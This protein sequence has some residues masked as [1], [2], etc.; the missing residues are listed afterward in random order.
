M[1][2]VL[3]LGA[4]AEN[5]TNWNNPYLPSAKS[6]QQYAIRYTTDAMSHDANSAWMKVGYDDSNWTLGA[7]PVGSSG[8]GVPSGT[9]ALGTSINSPS[10][11]R[12]IRREFTLDRDLSGKT[13]YMACGHDDEGAIWIDGTQIISWGNAWDDKYVH[14]MTSEQTALLTKGKHVIAIWA[15][16]NDG[17]YYWDCGLYGDDLST[18]LDWGKNTS[19]TAKYMFKDTG[20]SGGDPGENA[21]RQAAVDALTDPVDDAAGYDWTKTNYNDASWGTMSMPCGSAWPQSNKGTKWNGY[22]NCYWFRRSF[23]LTSADINKSVTLENVHDDDYEIYINGHLLQRANGW[24]DNYS[25]PVKLAIPSE[26][27]LIGENVIA[28]EVQQNWGGSLFDCRLAIESIA[29]VTFTGTASDNRFDGRNG[30]EEMLDGDLDTK[31]EAWPNW[32]KG[33]SETGHYGFNDD[34]GNILFKTST[35][36]YV[37]GLTLYTAGDTQDHPKRNPYEWTLF[38]SN[39]DA[40]ETDDTHSSWVKIEQVNYAQ[41]PT[42]NKTGKYFKFNPSQ[43]AYKYFKFHVNRL[44]GQDELQLAELELDYSTTAKSPIT[45]LADG[46][47]YGGEGAE[48]IFDGT[49]DTKWCKSNNASTNWV[50][51][52]TAKPIWVSN[53]IIQTAHN[54]NEE[55]RDPKKFKLYA[56]LDAAPTTDGSTT[57]WT[58]IDSETDASSTIPTDRRAFVDFTIDTPGIYQYF[59][60]KVEEIR[61]SDASFQ[62]SEFI[63]GD[64]IEVET[65]NISNPTELA[66]LAKRV[67]SGE[68]RVIAKITSDIVA[69]GNFASIGTTTNKFGGRFDGQG[70]TITISVGS[71]SE[72]Q[73]LIGCADTGASISNVIVKGAV[74]GPARCGGVLGGSNGATGTIT[75][76]NCGNEASVTVAG[77]NAGGV[78]GCNS[79]GSAKYYLTNCYN[80]GIIKGGS[81][82]AGISGWLGS[83]AVV[84]NCYNIGDVTGVDGT[85]TFARWGSGTYVNCYN[86]LAANEFAGRTDSYP[87]DKVRSGE[88]CVALGNAFTQDLSGDNYPTFGSKTVTA[89]KWFND[90]DVDVYYNKVD[91]DYTVYQLN[92]NEENTKYAVPGAGTVTAKNVSVARNIPAGQWIGLCLPFDYD[93]P[94]GWDVRELDHVNGSGESASMV[95]DSASSIEAGKPY[96]VNPTET[97]TNITAENKTISAA[98][99]DVSDS[100]VTMKG[101]LKKDMIQAGDFY[102][103][104]SSQV[105]KLNVSEVALKGF[106]AYFTVD[107]GSGVK[108]LSFDIEDD[109]TGI[110]SLTP[111]LFEGDGAI[112]NIAGQRIS[113][114]QKGINIVNGKKVLR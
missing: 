30:H 41:M 96:I 12:F 34:N 77:Q 111:A 7:G 89:G 91:D 11:D 49:A 61:G 85:K 47:G 103:N 18:N 10:G 59:M 107:G 23:L 97:V 84:T 58:E 105:K 69:D 4:W 42:T 43:T 87:M 95:F 94:S 13:I 110:E 50:I 68:S 65:Y 57:G 28:A 83:D 109:A 63:F 80:T 33:D 113:K 112:Y 36:I 3:S 22:Y 25:S 73:G 56:A 14:T 90:A 9:A 1:L 55:N 79:S 26:Y 39:D 92:L 38:G 100:G 24:S 76:L 6:G 8:Y 51:F 15:K 81:E 27:L 74:A 48:N 72:F 52:K 60:L 45:R 40:A 62:L 71:S 53:Y 31:W 17:G 54:D 104:T 37:N 19:W 32:G 67:N 93:I 78:V 108:A 86:K 46:G 99:T 64:A 102:I 21:E 16:N 98:T 29:T 75:L 2:S 114:M 88:L 101:R 66:N 5:P 20:Y 106:R 82:S 70:H 35:P 44:V